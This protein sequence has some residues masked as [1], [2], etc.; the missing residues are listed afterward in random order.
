MT[1]ISTKLHTRLAAKA[2]STDALLQSTAQMVD[3]SAENL[4]LVDFHLQVLLKVQDSAEM[5]HSLVHGSASQALDDMDPPAVLLR[6]RPSF[7]QSPRPSYSSTT[8]QSDFLGS[9]F[10]LT[11]SPSPSATSS[12][13]STTSTS[14]TSPALGPSRSNQLFKSFKRIREEEEQD[15]DSERYL[16]TTKWVRR[17]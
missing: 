11:S 3:L 1:N 16:R 9:P 14:P 13:S 6:G 2:S 8:S 12:Q 7:P 15:P 17:E 4:L 10:L 5:V